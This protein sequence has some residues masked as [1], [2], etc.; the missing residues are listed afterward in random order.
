MLSFGVLLQNCRDAIL[1]SDKTEDTVLK[2]ECSHAGLGAVTFIQ[3]K[4]K[5]KTRM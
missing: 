4:K 2:L 1:Q 3:G 5:K